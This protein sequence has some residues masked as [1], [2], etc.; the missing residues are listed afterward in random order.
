LHA[1]PGVLGP[2]LQ[3][4]QF[5]RG[6]ATAAKQIGQILLVLLDFFGPPT[7]DSR[8]RLVDFLGPNPQFGLHFGHVVL[9]RHIHHRAP[10]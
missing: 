8:E 10:S 2:H 5:V 4:S 3:L 7:T 1:L 9:V 6:Q